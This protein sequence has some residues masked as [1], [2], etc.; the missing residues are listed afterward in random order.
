MKRQVEV[1][2]ELS[3]CDLRNPILKTAT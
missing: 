2:E 3:S 1:R